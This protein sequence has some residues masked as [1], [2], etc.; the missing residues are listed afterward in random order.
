[1]RLLRSRTVQHIALL[2]ALYSFSALAMQIGG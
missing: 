1:M 2:V